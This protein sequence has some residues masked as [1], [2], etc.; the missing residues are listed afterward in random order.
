[1][2]EPS[3]PTFSHACGVRSAASGSRNGRALLDL[4]GT[5]GKRKRNSRAS[6][7]ESTAKLFKGFDLCENSA[8]DRVGIVRQGG[9]RQGGSSARPSRNLA[10]LS[11]WTRSE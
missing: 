8:H 3:Q 1:L 9:S 6:G 11:I 10:R 2:R 7:N 5:N 4:G